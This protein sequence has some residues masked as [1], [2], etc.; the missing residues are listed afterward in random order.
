MKLIESQHSQSHSILDGGGSG[1]MGLCG[2]ALLPYAAPIRTPGGR[3][4]DAEGDAERTPTY[5]PGS[6]SSAGPTTWDEFIQVVHL[7]LV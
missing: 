1:E 3:R 4:A 5:V 7:A 2:A 6:R